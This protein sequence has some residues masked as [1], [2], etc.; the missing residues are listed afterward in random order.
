M[1]DAAATAGTTVDDAGG[2]LPFNVRDPFLGVRFC[3][4]LVGI[5]PSRP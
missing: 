2:N 1:A 5:F 4:A 3:I